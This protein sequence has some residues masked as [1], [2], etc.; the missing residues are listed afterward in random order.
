MGNDH[1]EGYF[2]A[3]DLTLQPLTGKHGHGEILKMETLENKFGIDWFNNFRWVT[4]LLGNLEAY[5]LDE[6]RLVLKRQI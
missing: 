5:V 3:Q 1:R 6:N 2:L 4:A